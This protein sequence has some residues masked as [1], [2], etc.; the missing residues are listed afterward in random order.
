MSKA[1]VLLVGL[2]NIGETYAHTRHNAG[3]DCLALIAE[4]EGVAFKKESKFLGEVARL[5]DLWLLKPGTL[6]NRSGSAVAAL[7]RYYKIPVDA[8]FVIHDE[9][10]LPPGVLRL[11][12]GGGAGGHNGIRDIIQT[13]GADFHRIRIGIGRAGAGANISFVLSRPTGEEKARLLSVYD[14]V[15]ENLSLITTNF[16]EAQKQLHTPA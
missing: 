14:T 15:H 1:P 12:K 3:F 11:K 13:I 7:S 5:H 4:R 2:G 10:D 6:M 8:I 9:M 16:A